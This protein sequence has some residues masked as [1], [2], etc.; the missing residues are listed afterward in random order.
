MQYSASQVEPDLAI[1]ASGGK[2]G[3]SSVTGWSFNDVALVSSYV[4]S[5]NQVPTLGTLSIGEP[6]EREYSLKMP[7]KATLKN[8]VKDADLYII[9]LV[10]DKQ[11]K[12]IVNAAKAAIT[13]ANP[14]AIETVN[15]TDDTE[16]ARYTLD[17]RRVNN[18]QKGL[19]IVRM[20]N[21]KTVKV[22][23]K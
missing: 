13:V 12:K 11:S 22:I 14:D 15:A 2:Y 9:A 1:F 23:N 17:G 18:A 5:K 19:N 10:V 6:V 7:T 21:G 4:S 8:A 16:V 20:A 3:K